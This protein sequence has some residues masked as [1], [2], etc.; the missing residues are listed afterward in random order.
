MSTA[1][2]IVI[3]GLQISNW[4]REVLEENRRGGV[5]AV[6][7]TCAV[8]E[9]PLETIRTISRLHVLLRQNSDIADLAESVDDIVRCEREGKVGLLLGFQN[10]SP[11][12]DDYTMVDVFHRLG[13]RV[14]QLTYNIQNLVGGACYDP[15]DSGLTRFG[16]HIVAE[17]NRTGM[18]IDLSHVGDRTCR[19]AIDA[20]S[21][22]VAITHA[23]PR[24]FCESP[25]NKPDDVLEAVAARGGVVGCCLYPMVVAEDTSRRSYCEMVARLVD[26]IGPDHVAMGSDAVR[27]WDDAFVST[28][29]SGRWQPVDPE[30]PAPSWPQWP[31]WF[32]SPE[33]FPS[34]RDGLIDVGL[35]DVVVDKLLGQN[36]LRLLG[37]V[38]SGTAADG[39]HGRA[40]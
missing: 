15:H 28:L 20:S 36:W 27:G 10:A 13:V 32:Q 31:S 5:H 25:R 21:M 1:P 37:Q 14:A 35:D 40:A 30:A 29:R 7:A 8:W 18:L 38:F 22:P 34:L 26:Q 12:G 39:G 19:D 3:D 6:N 9:G 24:W 11:F 2:P 23:N 16:Q 17:M 4:S 33:D